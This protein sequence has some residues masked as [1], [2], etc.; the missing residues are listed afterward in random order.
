M[1]QLEMG[2]AWVLEPT[3]F[4]D[5]R[6]SFHEWYRGAE[7][8]EATGYDLALVQ[9]NCSVSRRGVLRGIHFAD[10]PPGQAKYVTC[11]R[12]AVLDVV[13]D[14]RVGS[15]AYGQWEAERLDEETRRAVFLAE[16][17]GHA[18]M[19]LTD[20]ATVVYLC[21]A[22]YAPKREHG[23]HP[24]DPALGITW[25]QGIEPVL[26]PKDAEAPSLAEAERSGLLPTYADC[27]AHYQRLRSG[28]FS[29]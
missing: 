13:V 4:P 3:V 27:S 17:L 6:G 23:V 10:V 2:D 18:F 14:I 8:R 25:P 24:L 29:G 9:A 1:R 15:P 19:A 11:V 7:F 12:G 5:D 26:S 22:G 28:E 20:D 21:S 16:G